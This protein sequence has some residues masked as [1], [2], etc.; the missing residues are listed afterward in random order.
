MNKSKN[1]SFIYD[2]V[3]CLEVNFNKNNSFYLEMEGLK[4]HWLDVRNCIKTD[5]YYRNAGLNWRETQ[6]L[7]K[8]E[9]K[10]KSTI[11]TQGLHL[12]LRDIQQL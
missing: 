8:N 9:T 12:T 2:Q 5:S 4:N 11:V 3:V 6:K 1:H 7:I 10:N